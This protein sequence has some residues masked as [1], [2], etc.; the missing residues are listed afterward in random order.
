MINEI[1][2]PIQYPPLDLV[3]CSKEP[4]WCKKEITKRLILLL[5]EWT[6]SRPLPFI[7]HIQPGGPGPTRP[8]VIP[9]PSEEDTLLYP[10]FT[11][12][13]I[14][15]IGTSWPNAHDS[16]TGSS[17]TDSESS[18]SRSVRAREN[19][20]QYI[21]DRSF[22]DFNLT[23]ISPSKTVYAVSLRIKKTGTYSNNVSIQEG[24]Q[25]IP[26]STSDYPSFT[27]LSF[28]HVAWTDTFN[29]IVF[30]S[31]GIAFIQSKL[32]STAKLCARDY[33]HDYSNISPNVA[34][35]S[36]AG[37]YY[38]NAAGFDDDPLLTITTS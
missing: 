26:I 3:R 11:D 8:P 7:T 24:T 18:S 22:F 10:N 14:H 29:T 25:N 17:K 27:G 35:I 1:K 37:M 33:D 36:S 2:A 23:S 34:E 13:R 30:N 6:R 28:G 32:G 19:F 21:I 38:R 5:L 31:L 9:S 15:K 12:G 16:L 4:L 20:G